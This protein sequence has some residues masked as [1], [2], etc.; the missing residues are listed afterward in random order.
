M[1]IRFDDLN[2]HKTNGHVFNNYIQ[3]FIISTVWFSFKNCQGV[4]QR[5]LVSYRQMSIQRQ[6]TIKQTA[7]LSY[8]QYCR[9]YNTTQKE[10]YKQYKE[11]SQSTKRLNSAINTVSIPSHEQNIHQKH[12][13]MHFSMI[14]KKHHK[15][16]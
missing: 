4:I 14:S 5:I 13:F 16:I 9:Q 11:S 8:L 12:P 2:N 15:S 7:D 1:S 3:I 6:T 10:I